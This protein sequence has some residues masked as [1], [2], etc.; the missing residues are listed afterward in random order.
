MTAAGAAVA[1]GPLRVGLDLAA[2]G[3]AGTLTRTSQVPPVASGNRVI[4]QRGDVQEWYVN[5]PA[6]IEQGFTVP[7]APAGSGPLTLSLA[8]S[9]NGQARL[10]PAGSIDFAGPDG[11]SI[12]YGDLTATDALGHRLNSHLAL[13]GGSVQISVDT[14][15]ARFPVRIDPLL[16]QGAALS[17][18]NEGLFG[19][20]VAVSADGTTALIG[21]PASNSY[22]GGAWIF[23]LSES[24]NW[25]EQAELSGGTEGASEA[26]GS[27]AEECSFGRAVALSADGNTALVGAPR[28][29]GNRGAALV[30]TRQ[31]S[32]WTQTATLTGGEEERGEGRL[33]KSVGLSA[34]GKSAIA[35]A[36]SEAGGIGAAWIFENNGTSWVHSG[37][38]L[39][40]A[41]GEHPETGG[42]HFG[43]SVAISGETAV[44]GAPSNEPKGEAM[45]SAYVF[46]KGPGGWTQ[47]GQSLTPSGTAAAHSKFG[48]SVAVAGET[49][50]VGAPG[51]EGGVGAAY[52]F[53][54]DEGN[55]DLT[56]AQ[57]LTGGAEEEGEGQFGTA[58]AISDDASA[59][60]VGAPA[61]AK[62]KGA[63][64]LLTR[65]GST[66]AQSGRKIEGGG[67]LAKG[68][69]GTSVALS[70]DGMAAL[71]GG[72]RDGSTTGAV[73]SFASIAHGPPEVSSIHPKSG[74]SRGGTLVTIKGSGF[75]LDSA[76]TIGN[77]AS[78]VEVL[79][80]TELRARTTATEPGSYEVVVSDSEGTSTE[81]PSFTYM[82]SA[83]KEGSI[84]PTVTSISPGS[85]PA[86]GDTEVTIHGT[87]FAAGATVSIGSLAGSVEVISPTE[88]RAATLPTAAGTYD[89][90]VSDI[91]GTSTGGPAY[92]FTSG[93]RRHDQRKRRV[94]RARK[95][96]GPAAA[97]GARRQRQPQARERHGLHQASRQQ[98]VRPARAGTAGA[99]RDDHRRQERTSAA[100]VRHPR[101]QD[102]DDHLLLRHLQAHPDTQRRGDGHPLGRQ[103]RRLPAGQQERAAGIGGGQA[104]VRQ[105]RRAQTLGRRPRSL[106]D[107]GQLRQRSGPRHSL[108]HRGSLRRD[109]HL[110]RHRQGRGDEPA[111]PPPHGRQGRAQPP[112]QRLS[113]FGR[114]A[115]TPGRR[116][117][118]RTTV[119]RPVRSDGAGPAPVSQPGASSSAASA[120][121]RPASRA[122]SIWWNSSRPTPETRMGIVRSA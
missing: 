17:E 49:A 1:S 58:V 19:F 22:A 122:W 120:A 93:A 69:F 77:S 99:V 55:F 42:G 97:A 48:Y 54:E 111:H 38:K 88:I 61:D 115:R 71:I 57:L 12:T 24:L 31:G 81:G 117:Q 51:Y 29:D 101:R 18:G 65:T 47:P 13:R 108:A 37:P 40:G 50:V 112:R 109:A 114:S 110:R 25:E 79:S 74:P 113:L 15:G 70:G 33:G 27:S 23:T 121:R 67:E 41:G 68:W 76:V 14:H 85:G 52:A 98:Q 95:S 73:W 106:H 105:A 44:V 63:A 10:T 2:A 43:F 4:Y 28:N 9:G 59:V 36:S 92:T 21:A 39:T 86:T 82:Q 64:W 6:G 118:T 84:A 26:C 75:K 7:S 62:R 16:Q 5:G 46:T 3:S 90:Y 102:R 45:G 20:S 53:S 8:L 119:R 87:G 32:T 89:V 72:S 116:A 104:A 66:F 56:P 94:R 80:E 91:N 35:G 96:A 107:E 78:S 30:F 100:D 60:L 11:S 34:D 83:S 103:L